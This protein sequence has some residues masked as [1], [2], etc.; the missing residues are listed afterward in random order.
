MSADTI[1]VLIYCIDDNEYLN[2]VLL[3]AKNIFF[4]SYKK[5]EVFSIMHTKF[6]MYKL[7]RNLHF[8][9]HIL[10]NEIIIL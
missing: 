3:A 10:Q 4:R 1:Y 6:N 9:M 7:C 5:K 8:K 2:H